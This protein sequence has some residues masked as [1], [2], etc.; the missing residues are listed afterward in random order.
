MSALVDC[1]SDWTALQVQK[2]G[3]KGAVVGLSDG[4]PPDLLHHVKRMV[5]ASAH[6]RSLAPVFEV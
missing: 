4:V 1:I 5:E 2:A 6:K 3:V